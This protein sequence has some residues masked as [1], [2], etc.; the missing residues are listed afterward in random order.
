MVVNYQNIVDLAVVENSVDTLYFQ[1]I[2]ER[3]LQ[4]NLILG[5]RQ[6]REKMNTMKNYYVQ[7]FHQYNMIIKKTNKKFKKNSI[8]VT[9]DIQPHHACA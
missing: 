2:I 6:Q 4:L 8:R 1:N 7:F 9:N 3:F 5:N